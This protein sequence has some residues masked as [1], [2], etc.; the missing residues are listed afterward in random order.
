MFFADVGFEF[1]TAV[2]VESAVFWD[3]MPCIPVKVS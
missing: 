3:I 1:L 2:I